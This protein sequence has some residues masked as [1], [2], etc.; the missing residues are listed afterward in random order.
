M[1]C[2]HSR[3]GGDG[4]GQPAHEVHATGVD[5]HGEIPVGLL[6]VQFGNEMDEPGRG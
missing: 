3:D 4:V 1:E 2:T 5:V 6:G